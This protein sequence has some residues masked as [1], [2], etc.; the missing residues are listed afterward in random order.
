[1]KKIFVAGALA[2]TLTSCSSGW[3]CK[4]RYVKSDIHKNNDTHRVA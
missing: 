1:M 4:A 3:S 2:L